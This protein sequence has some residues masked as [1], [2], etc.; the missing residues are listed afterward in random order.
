MKTTMVKIV[1]AKNRVVYTGTK[2]GSIHF[3]NV[4]RNKKGVKQWKIST[5]T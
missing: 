5:V 1:D 3:L 4:N 2:F